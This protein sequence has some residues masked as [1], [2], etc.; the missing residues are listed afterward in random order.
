MEDI[1]TMPFAGEKQSLIKTTAA[2]IDNN[3]S[4]TVTHYSIWQWPTV[5]SAIA[6]I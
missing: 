5:I 3:E 4:G 6:K 1:L 2:S